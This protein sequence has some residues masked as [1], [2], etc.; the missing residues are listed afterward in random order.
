M[1]PSFPS[2]PWIPAPGQVALSYLN[3][4]DR[5]NQRPYLTG[6][7]II[8]F[9]PLRSIFPLRSFFE[10]YMWVR[11]IFF[12]LG[13]NFLFP[14]K[15]CFL[16]SSGCNPPFQHCFLL[17]YLAVLSALFCQCGK[18]FFAVK[19]PTVKYSWSGLHYSSHHILSCDSFIQTTWAYLQ[20]LPVERPEVKET[21]NQPFKYLS[22]YI[23]FPMWKQTK[24]KQKT[25]T[26]QI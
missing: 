15:K 18:S 13:F 12:L 6:V 5:K 3:L 9:F 22:S 11:I 23:V 2:C 8:S 20:S 19:Q 4:G 16:D 21:L 7:H 25:T 26:K 17:C 10:F 24:P 1:N 14:P